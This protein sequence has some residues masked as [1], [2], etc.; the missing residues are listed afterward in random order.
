MAFDVA[1]CDPGADIKSTTTTTVFFFFFFN[2]ALRD[3][4]ASRFC[5]SK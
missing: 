4:V 2:K 5:S 3:L 1:L